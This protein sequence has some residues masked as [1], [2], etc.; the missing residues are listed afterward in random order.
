[1]RC[2][3]LVPTC[4]PRKRLNTENTASLILVADPT[5]GCRN[6]ANEN[7]LDLF[8][9]WLDWNWINLI[10][11]GEDSQSMTKCTIVKYT[12]K[13]SLASKCWVLLGDYKSRFSISPD[14]EK[15]TKEWYTSYNIF[16]QVIDL[17]QH[18]NL[19]ILD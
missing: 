14:Y 15:Y 2:S 19:A 16:L 3:R 18:H 7:M 6:H 4:L 13:L 1:M 8:I 17:W 9:W 11:R 5:F 12:H 10:P